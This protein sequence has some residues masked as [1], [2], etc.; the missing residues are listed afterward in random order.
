MYYVTKENTLLA[1]T[2]TLGKTL[3]LHD[4][5]CTMWQKNI[6]L[7]QTVNLDKFMTFYHMG[8]QLLGN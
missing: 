4:E 2:V 7:A 6:L 1:Q 3:V 8:V 5:R